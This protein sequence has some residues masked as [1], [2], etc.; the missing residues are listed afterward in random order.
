MSLKSER[1]NMTTVNELSELRLEV[2]SSSKGQD[3]FIDEQLILSEVLQSMFDAKLVDSEDFNDVYFR[4]GENE[5]KI[6]GYAINES[7]ERLQIF[8]VSEFFTREELS[9]SEI[10]VSEKSSYEK[11]FKRAER[12]L[13]GLYVF[14]PLVFILERIL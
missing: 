5:T 3:E 13:L 4:S 9:E 8:L 2:L 14:I 7:Q 1:L 11:Q 12:L 10:L 6:N